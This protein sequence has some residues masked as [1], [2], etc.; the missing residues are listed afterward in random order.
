MLNFVNSSCEINA[1]FILIE[2]KLKI[3]AKVVNCYIRYSWKYWRELNLVVGP[4][5]AITKILADLNLV[6][7]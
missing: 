1:V 2:H 3:D 5:M 4:K 7:W 6:I